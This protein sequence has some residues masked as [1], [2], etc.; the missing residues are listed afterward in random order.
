MREFRLLFGQLLL[1]ARQ[2]GES[3]RGALSLG[4]GFR[5]CQIALR[6]S[7]FLRSFTQLPGV[8]FARL[9]KRLFQRFAL[10]G[11]TFQLLRRL[12]LLALDLLGQLSRLRIEH[13]M[14]RRQFGGLLRQVFF[15][16]G[17]H[18]QLGLIEPFL[19]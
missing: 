6:L 14:L 16:I 3:I 9:L 12:G 8:F 19:G 7:Q 18:L 1:L 4:F 2:L 17:Q 15:A 11:Q 10:L 13:R 5:S